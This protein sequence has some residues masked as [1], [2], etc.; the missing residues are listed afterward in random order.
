MQVRLR[1]A[2]TLKQ[3]QIGKH[4]QARAARYLNLGSGPRG[5]ASKEWI[6]V[7]GW[8]DRNVH[9]AI[10]LN[11]PLPFADNYF[12]GIFSEHVFEHFDLEQGSRFCGNA[13]ESL[14]RVD[15]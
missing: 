1:N 10:D 2:L 8:T 7:D 13:F 6:N 11:R 4:A 12:A 3:K 9:L 15:V 14:N 5:V